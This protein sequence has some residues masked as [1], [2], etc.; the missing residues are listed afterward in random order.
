MQT[1]Y[2]KWQKYQAGKQE[3]E[4]QTGKETSEN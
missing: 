3:Q 1:S 4:V 2:W